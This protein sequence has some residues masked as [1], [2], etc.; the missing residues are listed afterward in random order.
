M[1]V[2]SVSWNQNKHNVSSNHNISSITPHFFLLETF[3]TKSHFWNTAL[4]PSIVTCCTTV[5]W[6]AF[7]YHVLSS[8]HVWSLSPVLGD[9]C[10]L[11]LL[12]STGPWC[13]PFCVWFTSYNI[14]IPSSICV[15]QRTRFCSTYG[16]IAF[17]GLFVPH[18]P[19]LCFSWWTL[20]FF[21]FLPF[22]KSVPTVLM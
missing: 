13:L 22:V 11:I 9:Q 15:L 5:H 18:F 20:Q 19:Y 4:P 6:V 21:P 7:F 16:W 10:F 8:E 2:H 12:M 3:W 1:C 17:L 14:M